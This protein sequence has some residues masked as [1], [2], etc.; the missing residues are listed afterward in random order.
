MDKGKTASALMDLQGTMRRTVGQAMPQRRDGNLPPAQL[1]VLM[2]LH[3]SGPMRMSELADRTHTSRPNLTMLVERLHREGYVRRIRSDADRRRVLIEL[4]DLARE[5]LDEIH[6]RARQEIGAGL[7]AYNAKELK[8][9]EQCAAR[10][11]V[12]L[13][14]FEP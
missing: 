5:R 11:C 4:T 8:E 1:G 6:T 3:G 12:L 2:L 13:E 7:D 10:L 9:I 14:K